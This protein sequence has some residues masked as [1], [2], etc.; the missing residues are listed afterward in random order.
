MMQ[1][2]A[3]ILAVVCMV[4][5]GAIVVPVVWVLVGFRVQLQILVFPRSDG[6]WRIA[7]QGRLVVGDGNKPMGYR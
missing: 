3:L 7:I 4:G 6:S 5:L 1:F 2:A